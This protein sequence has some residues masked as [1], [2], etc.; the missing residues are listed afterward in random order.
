MASELRV[1]TLKDANGNNSIATSTVAEGSAKAWV[2]FDGTA[3]DGTVDLTG[4]RDSFN[5]SA[6]VDNTTGD[7][8]IDINANMN[9]TDYVVSGSGYDHAG[10]ADSYT[11]HMYHDLAAGSVEINNIRPTNN[12]SADTSYVGT[13]IHGDL[14]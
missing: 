10:T 7:Y 12:A 3:V 5:I 6:I 9:S 4:V 2:N 1:N 11:V 14:A 13:T 8:R